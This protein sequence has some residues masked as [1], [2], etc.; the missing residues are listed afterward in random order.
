MTKTSKT[1]D[2][3]EP[4][5]FNV[6]IRRLAARL[7]ILVQRGVLRP[8]GLR[9]QEWR[10]LWSL[11]R[12]GDTHVRELG[13]RASVDAAHVSRLL[14]KFGEKGLIK[15]MPDP[16]DSRRTLFQISPEGRALYEDVKPKAVA[17]SAEF[18]SLYTAEEYETLMSLIDRALTHA[19]VLLEQEGAHEGEPD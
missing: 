16:K 8:Y 1:V 18:Q 2:G 6:P 10:V 4:H 11:A 3:T 12:E 9:I 14:K 15:R 7:Q 17:F 19:D 13:R 5:I